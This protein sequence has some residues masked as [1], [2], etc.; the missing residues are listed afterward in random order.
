MGAPSDEYEALAAEVTRRLLHGEDL[1]KLLRK[2]FT[3]RQMS[4][5]SVD[6]LVAL[7]ERL[8]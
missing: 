4:R 8:T 5:S 6:E 2:W 7:Q 1:R 3:R